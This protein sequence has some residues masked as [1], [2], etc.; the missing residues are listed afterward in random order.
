MS[1]TLRE[2]ITVDEA[3]ATIATQ[4]ATKEWLTKALDS[5]ES[6]AISGVEYVAMANY[7]E[8]ERHAILKIQNAFDKVRKELK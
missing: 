8:R 5:L 2:R 4:A 7:A 6:T 1:G 3:D